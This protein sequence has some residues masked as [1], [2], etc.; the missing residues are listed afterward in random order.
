MNEMFKGTY[1]LNGW[2]MGVRPYF[3]NDVIG[4]CN[5]TAGTGQTFPVIAPSEKNR[6]CGLCCTKDIAIKVC[7]KAGFVV[8]VFR[9]LLGCH[10]RNTPQLGHADE[11]RMIRG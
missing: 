1:F 11:D 10:K 4:S 7:G 9:R 8:I 2:I 5:E 3:R 6:V